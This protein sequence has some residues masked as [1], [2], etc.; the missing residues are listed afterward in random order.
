MSVAATDTSANNGIDL[1]LLKR[2]VDAL[3]I[4][5]QSK[6]TPW[7]RSTSTIISIMALLFS[8]GTTSVSYL[9]TQSQD[10]QSLRTELRGVLQRLT[11]L[12]KENVQMAKAYESDP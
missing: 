12:P 4:V 8:F 6:T 3:Q 1:V 2:E 7:Y 5:V 10:V 9:R 11:E